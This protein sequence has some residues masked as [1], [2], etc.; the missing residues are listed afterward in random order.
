MLIGAPR[1]SDAALCRAMAEGQSR[2]LGSTV[3]RSEHTS[4]A[5][6]RNA[7]TR[8][9]SLHRAGV[10]MRMCP[11]PRVTTA[12]DLRSTSRYAYVGAEGGLE[13]R[14][15]GDGP[16]GAVGTLTITRVPRPRVLTISSE[17][18]TPL[19]RSCMERRP[20]CPGNL[21]LA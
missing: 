9:G 14:A 15:L 2:A 20:R 7:A 18:A 1:C 3:W 17:P 21:P 16:W 10:R 12:P 11:R 5:R 8:F 19:A 6:S 13:G 4:E